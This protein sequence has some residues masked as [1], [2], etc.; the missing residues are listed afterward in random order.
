MRLRIFTTALPLLFVLYFSC[1]Y[2]PTQPAAQTEL[3][4]EDT[5]LVDSAVVF[6]CYAYSV[7]HFIMDTLELA[8]YSEIKVDFNGN[9][10]SDGTNITVYYNT[11]SL[12][13][14]SVYSVWNTAGINNDHSFSF[15]SPSGR[16]LMEIRLYIN[17]P[18][19][20]E[21]EFKFVRVRDLKIF[22]I[23]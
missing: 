3:L 13:N 7:R 6:G 20:G 11:D 10:N 19:C 9:A 8:G 22:G 17:P 16:T 1:S 12:S 18:V 23:K 14:Y 4:Y 2:N 5:G 15:P 21:G